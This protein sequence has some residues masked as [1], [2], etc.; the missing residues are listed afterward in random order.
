[1]EVDCLPFMRERNSD[2]YRMFDLRHA[3]THNCAL[4]LAP[5]HTDPHTHTH[6]L[7]YKYTQTN[8][9]TH[10][11]SHTHSHWVNRSSPNHHMG[12][13][14]RSLQTFG[15]RHKN[16][17]KKSICNQDDMKTKTPPEQ[18]KTG[19]I[20]NNGRECRGREMRWEAE[21]SVRNLTGEERSE[22]L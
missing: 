7:A 2:Q 9:H 15:R 21:S 4:T 6:L 1:M 14:G 5:K 11:L 8:T 19:K 20:V 13:H 17:S 12:Q 3:Y 10:S 18:S 16:S 22:R